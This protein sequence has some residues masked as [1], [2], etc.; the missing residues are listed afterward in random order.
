MAKTYVLKCRNE[1]TNQVE[2]VRTTEWPG[3]RIFEQDGV[4]YRLD[5]MVGIEGYKV[6]RGADRIMIPI[7]EPGSPPNTA[8]SA[9]RQHEIAVQRNIEDVVGWQYD[10][11]DPAFSKFD[12]NPNS[13]SY[14]QPVFGSRKDIQEGMANLRE[15]GLEVGYGDGLSK[16]EP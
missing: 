7:G 1:G 13:S 2:F 3:K 5:A 14:G 6:I 16:I 11:W 4:T 15:R 9:V 8:H 10:Q 12:E